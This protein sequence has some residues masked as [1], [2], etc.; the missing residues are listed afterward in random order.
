MDM[1]AIKGISFCMFV[2]FFTGAVIGLIEVI[3]F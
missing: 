2:G 1:N 3:L